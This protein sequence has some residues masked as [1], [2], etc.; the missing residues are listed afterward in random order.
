MAAK[1]KR[2]AP[3]QKDPKRALLAAATRLFAR[4]GFSGVSVRDIAL[5]AK[6]NHGLVHRHFGSKEG[7]LRAVMQHQADTLAQAAGQGIARGAAHGSLT[8]AVF[9]AA[10]QGD[11]YWRILA[12][13]LLDGADPREL[14]SDFPT[15]RRIIEHRVAGGQ[16]RN[17]AALDV[18]VLAAA[19]LGFLV[20]EPF[21]RAA[22]GFEKQ[23]RSMLPRAFARR[24]GALAERRA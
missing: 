12:R 24:L 4:R 20:F 17:E 1:P 6:V 5:A 2:A 16:K 19:G 3:R 21:L 9:A 10:V 11:A 7:L 14:Q 13:Q 23:P 8:E 18:V 15:L 22:A